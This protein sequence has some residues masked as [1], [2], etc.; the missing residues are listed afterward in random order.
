[1]AIC[2][3]TCLGDS[4]R[5]AVWGCKELEMTERLNTFRVIGNIQI[6]LA[7]FEGA[8]FKYF[9]TSPPGAL[10]LSAP[11]VSSSVHV[12]ESPGLDWGS[13]TPETGPRPVG[14]SKAG[15][16]GSFVTRA[17]FLLWQHTRCYFLQGP[18][19]Q[20]LRALLCHTPM[21]IMFTNT[22]VFS[23]SPAQSH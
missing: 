5:D 17:Q 7:F 14:C 15:A 10:S 21:A 16:T 19:V 4:W 11:S 23:L 12:P 13:S 2:S 1:M 20:T 3:S 22:C 18:E 8:E 6:S 9:K